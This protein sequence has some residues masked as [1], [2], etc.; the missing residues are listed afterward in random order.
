MNSSYYIFCDES[1]QTKDCF[2]I[3]GGIILPFEKIQQFDDTMKLYRKETSMFAELKWSKVSNQKLDEYKR[4][5]DF[6]FALNNNNAIHFK[7]MIIDT[8]QL[9][10]KKF[11]AGDKELGFYKFYYQLLLHSFGK[12]YYTPGTRFVV[13]LDQRTTKYRL[14]DLQKILNL[15]INKKYHIT[16]SPFVAVESVNSKQSE[17]MQVNDILLGAIGYLKNDLHLLAGSKFTKI[18]LAKYIASKTGLRSITSNTNFHQNR[19]SIWNFKLSK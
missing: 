14:S 17:V 12:K 19:F 9:N 10:H 11:N 16:T 1:R 3:L 5:V 2:M 4:F 18:E 7:A 15:G 6:F 13:K 8:H